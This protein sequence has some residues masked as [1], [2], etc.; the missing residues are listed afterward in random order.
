MR[1][2]RGCRRRGHRA[3]PWPG[4][5][6]EHP[7]QQLGA[8]VQVGVAAAE[9]TDPAYAEP[10]DRERR[11]EGGLRHGPGQG[12]PP[13]V[14]DG[15]GRARA[16]RPTTTTSGSRRP[17]SRAAPSAARGGRAAPARSAASTWPA[18]DQTLGTLLP[19]SSPPGPPP[20]RWPVH[21]RRR[22]AASQ[23]VTR[24]RGTDLRGGPDRRRDRLRGCDRCIPCDGHHGGA[25]RAGT[26]RPSSRRS[27]TATP[28]PTAC[29][30][31]A[32]STPPAGWPAPSRATAT[33]T[34]WSPRRS[35]RCCPSWCAATA[36]T[37]RSAPYLLTAV[38]RL[39]VGPAPRAGPDPPHRRRA[40]PRRGR[41]RSATPRWPASSPTAAARAFASLPERWQLV[42]WHTE[43]EGQRPADV[44]PLLGLSPN[45]VSQLAHRAREGLRQAFVSM[46]VQ[47]T[48]EPRSACQAT[49]ANLG[50]YIRAG[51]SAREASRVSAHLECCRPCTAIYLE[52]VEVDTDLRGLLAPL[53]L[54]G[55]AAAY[56]SGRAGR[57]RA[58]GHVA[59]VSAG[60]CGAARARSWPVRRPPGVTVT[61]L[62]LGGAALIGTRH[63]RRRRPGRDR[64]RRRCR[65]SRSTRP[66]AAPQAGQAKPGKPRPPVDARRLPRPARP[67][68]TARRADHATDPSPQPSTD[69]PADPAPDPAARRHRRTRPAPTARTGADPTEDADPDTT[70]TRPPSTCG[71][72]PPRPA[73]ARPRW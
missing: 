16:A 68:P 60:S 33:P 1:R 46:H 47:D 62:V 67:R 73:S 51:L 28:T 27:A 11:P 39:D 44:A 29:S 20:A 34:T 14:L 65:P 61:A 43:V 57:G 18:A 13:G 41:S 6:A 26:T 31:S 42:L 49:R 7:G 3:R 53:L 5:V 64:R 40:R 2:P 50:A 63:E 69:P 9:D 4:S 21:W 54:G 12:Q 66:A 56:L 37:W 58:D 48:G 17:S 36:P 72:A 59:L 23:D 38:R 32:T 22:P 24:F 45:A 71:S 70:A 55:A 35:P 52:L 30:S 10:A 15:V 19:I 8:G 25:R